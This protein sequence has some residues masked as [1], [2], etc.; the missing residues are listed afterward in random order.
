MR[1]V[2]ITGALGGIGT[3]LVSAFRDAGW[4]VVA[5]DRLASEIGDCYIAADLE[6]LAHDNRA[7]ESFAASVEDAC[8]G[9]PLTALVNNAA[10]QIQASAEKLSAADWAETLCVNV[11]APLRLVQAFLPN[12]RASHG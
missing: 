8:R 7:L 9:A 11:T 3:A 4:R 2:L 12:L 10:V 1:A 5:T 6:R